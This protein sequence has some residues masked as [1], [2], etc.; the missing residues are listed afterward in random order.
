MN[1]LE[2]L[3]RDE[4]HEL[5]DALDVPALPFELPP[6]KR[7]A[8]TPPALFAQL[9]EVR[10]EWRAVRSSIRPGDADRYVN[11]AW[12]LKDLVAHAASWAEEFRHEVET[13]FRGD[14][15]DY[16]IPYVMSVIGP[17]EWNEEKVRARDP[18]SIEDSFDELD[19]ETLRLQDL[20]LQMT[21]TDLYQPKTFPLAPSGD[22]EAKWRGPSAVIIAAKCEHDRY[23]IAQ[24]KKRL[25]SWRED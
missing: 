7:A 19:A 20:L 1:E 15:L 4:W 2:A 12:T 10:E 6:V 17:T 22:P 18:Q 13:V 9:E 23:H 25:A 11:A 24:I 16:A 8:V 5:S 21:H 3:L 14:P